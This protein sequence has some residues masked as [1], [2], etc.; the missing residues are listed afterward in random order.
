MFLYLNRY[1]FFQ[2]GILLNFYILIKYLKKTLKYNII[3]LIIYYKN[4]YFSIL[5]LL[6][7]CLTYSKNVF[8][9]KFIL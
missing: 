2:L 7:T 1:P 8:K 9:I 5:L 6:N 3:Y 4:E